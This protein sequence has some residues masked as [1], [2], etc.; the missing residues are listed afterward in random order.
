MHIRLFYTACTLAT[1]FFTGCH[2]GGG[3]TT[4]SPTASDS[5]LKV[6]GGDY[7]SSCPYLTKDTA[8]NLVLSWISKKS[9][10]GATQVCYAVFSRKEKK[11]G[12]SRSVGVTRDVEPHGENMPKMV[13]S[14]SGRSLIFFPLSRPRPGNPYTAVVD[15]TSFNGQDNWTPRVPLVGDTAQSFDQRYF[16]AAA[17]P[18]G[19]TGVVWLNNSRPSGSTLYFARLLPD[20]TIDRENIVG[21]HTC[22]CCRTDLFVDD[23]G[24]IHVAW[25][26]IYHDSIRDMAY[27]FSGDGGRTFTPPRRISPDNW[28][29]NGCPHTGPSMARNA[30]GM[31]FAWYTMGGGEGVYYCHSTDGGLTFSRKEAVSEEPSARHPQIVSLP[32]N[33]LAIVWDEGVQYRDKY[34]QRIGLQLRGPSGLLLGTRYLTADSVNAVFPQIAILNNDQALVAYTQQQ[35]G[36]PQ[37]KCRLVKLTR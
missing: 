6:A 16:D 25:R 30:E 34:H 26:E 23:S 28:V 14:R 35:D 37:V 13:F 32:D 18:S 4:G 24:G 20:G 7:S 11:F 31:H 3:R 15:Y 10:D 2:T 21:R 5:F 12:P 1:L 9:K 29:V 19:G 8:G 27:A 36:S 33:D 22:Q 17:L